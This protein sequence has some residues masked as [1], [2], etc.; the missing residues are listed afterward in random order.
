DPALERA[1][2]RLGPEEEEPIDLDALRAEAGD[3]AASEEEL[4]LLALFG[5]EAEPLAAGGVDQRRAAYIREVVR[6][7]Q[8]TGV[9]EITIEEEGMRVSVRRT[10]ETV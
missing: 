2:E 4:L 10:A 8:D 1:I 3:L 6:I 5:E 7:V 9:G